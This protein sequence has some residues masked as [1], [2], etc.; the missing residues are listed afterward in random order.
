MPDLVQPRPRRSKGR[1]EVLRIYKLGMSRIGRDR[2]TGA[3]I[4]RHWPARPARGGDEGVAV[5]PGERFAAE[6]VARDGQAKQIGRDQSGHG[7]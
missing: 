4:R 6:G 1:V 2:S 5:L 7:L 3:A